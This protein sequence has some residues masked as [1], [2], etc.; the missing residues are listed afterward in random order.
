MHSVH[1]NEIQSIKYALAE[2]VFHMGPLNKV[3][4]V[5]FSDRR[6]DF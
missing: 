5:E 4:G 6:I 3:T 2:T 1:Q